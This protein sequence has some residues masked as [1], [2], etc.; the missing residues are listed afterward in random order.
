MSAHSSS[1][2][3][4]HSSEATRS[5]GGTERERTEASSRETRRTA[6][7]SLRD[8]P[9]ASSSI[10]AAAEAALHWREIAS[11]DQKIQRWLTTLG[12][13]AGDYWVHR[14]GVDLVT[15]DVRAH[16]DAMV[17]YYDFFREGLRLPLDPFVTD[18]LRRCWPSPA[19]CSSTPFG[20]W[21]PS[22]LCAGCSASSL[23][24][25]CFVF[26]SP[27]RRILD[28]SESPLDRFSGPS[29]FSRSFPIRWMGGTTRFS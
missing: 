27:S 10:S 4:D 9:R 2:D 24:T 29:G 26:S 23:P 19:I 25:T 11:S 22:R 3:E 7:F 6:A 13:D 8:G 14:E 18:F 15:N 21:W 20:S 17:F 1:G 28:R 16:G 12:V 5:E